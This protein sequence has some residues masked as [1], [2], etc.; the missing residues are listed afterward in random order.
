MSDN[1]D[2]LNQIRKIV[3]EENELI[4]KD[5]ATKKDVEVAIKASEDRLKKVILD[6]QE[7]TIETLKE[8]IDGQYEMTVYAHYSCRYRGNSQASLNSVSEIAETKL[9]HRKEISV[10]KNICS[11]FKR[12]S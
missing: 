8:Y 9:E 1:T 4:K 6:S 5:M 10:R 11:I 3:R 12:A 7:D 2:L